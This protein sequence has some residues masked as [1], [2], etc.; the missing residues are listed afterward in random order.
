MVAGVGGCYL[1]VVAAL[2]PVELSGVHDN[3]PE[4]CAVPAEELGGGVHHYVRAVLDRPDQVRSSEG[5]VYHQRYACR[6]GYLRKGVYIGD[7]TVGVAE[8]LY[9]DRSGIGLY[10]GLYF[11]QVMD[12]NEGGLNAELR[13][14]VGKK[15]VAAA[16]YGL[17]RHYVVS[18]LRQSLYGVGD[19]RSAR[20]KRQSR[21]AA[22]KGRYSLL[23]HVLRGVGEPAVDVARIRKPE[24]VRGVLAVMKNIRCSLIDGYRSGICRGV[25]LLLSYVELKCLKSVIAHFFLLDNV[26]SLLRGI[27]G[28]G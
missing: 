5:V 22:L 6:V 26:I 11:V 1:W 28:P 23:Q 17:L 21:N 20:R 14:G 9:E 18:L 12:V 2:L 4:S 19:G 8:G 10:R 27:C 13:K 16:V 7:V 3:A 15:V 24:P 25:C